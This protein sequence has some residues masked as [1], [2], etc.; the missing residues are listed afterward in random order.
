MLKLTNV[1]KYYQA[2]KQIALG[3]RKVNV[4]LGINELVAVVGESGS[5]KSTFLN[6]ISG[7]DT[8]EEGEMYL[9]GEETSQFTKKEWEDYRNSYV[10]FVFQNYNLIDS[11]TVLENVEVALTLVG[12]DAE[13]RRKKSLELIE[14]VGLTSHIH[15]KAVRLSGGQKQRVVIARA[16]A[17]DSPIIA[18][19]EPTGNLDSQSGEQIMK[20]LSEISKEKL[21]VIVT[22]NY[23][24]IAPYATRVLKFFDGELAS[25]TKLKEVTPKNLPSYDST[26]KKVSFWDNIK[27]GIKSFLSTPKKAIFSLLVFFVATLT[28]V[29]LSSG[30]SS[31][32]SSMSYSPIFRNDLQ[33]RM[34]VN[35]TDKSSFTQQ[36]YEK[37]S[38]IDKVR[39]I[40]TNEFSLDSFIGLNPLIDKSPDFYL[41]SNSFMDIAYLEETDLVIGRMP[42]NE[43]EFVNA[44][45]VYS[46]FSE[47][48]SNSLLGSKFEFYS[49]NPNERNELTLVGY[50][51]AS[52]FNDHNISFITKS[53]LDKINR[54]ERLQRYQSKFVFSQKNSLFSTF[55]VSLL[56]QNSGTLNISNEDSDFYY[57]NPQ[58]KPT[59][60][61]DN[62][63][64]QNQL[65]IATK[66]TVNRLLHY[67]DVI[68]SY[69]DQIGKLEK[70][71]DAT[72]SIEFDLSTTFEN[73]SFSNSILYMNQ[74]TY[75]S[76]YS[77]MM[78][79][80]IYQISVFSLDQVNLRF[81]QAKLNELG[82]ST[83]CVIDSNDN[84]LSQ[85]FSIFGQIM[86][87]L[88]IAT[89]G[90]FLYWFSYLI[91]KGLSNSK[92]KDYVIMRSIGA[93][94]NFITVMILVENMISSFIASILVILIILNYK[95]IPLDLFKFIFNMYRPF[96]YLA[97]ILV[98]LLLAFFIGLRLRKTLFKESINKTLK[99][100]NE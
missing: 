86:S 93:K 100:G 99:T 71:F 52:A 5:G 11:F 66:D 38:S 26:I 46:E 14:K 70:A 60:S 12:M 19:D 63:L 35:K 40:E 54:D 13:Y 73:S 72:Y 30:L 77:Y 41:L 43:F 74:V 62:N 79:P 85:M 75:D 76:L 29:T 39:Y 28:L 16:L 18:A 58:L 37:I 55:N 44:R 21:V 1:S 59:I 96:H 89:M 91:L 69:K 94:K 20:L 25:D 82:F 95:L 48:N 51:D 2:Q 3:L 68:I 65:K 15:Q 61:I 24:Q 33:N 50:V 17:K 83:F 53:Q 42:K 90:L 80:P 47:A 56:G 45:H 97:L 31:S 32:Q 36:D 9:N 81:V 8:Y 87:L 67:D 57:R 7:M 84:M 88:M 64:P 23:E 92:K 27:L 34:V 6:I 4:E 98:S 10:G 22:H 49:S 78:N